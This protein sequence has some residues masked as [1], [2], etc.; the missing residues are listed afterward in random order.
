M[1]KKR[2]VYVVHGYRATS[3][4][5]WFP[6][7]KK[8]LE[9][10]D[11]DVTVFDMPNADAPNAQEWDTYLDDNIVPCNEH[12]IL[13]G[14]SLGCI[15][16]LRYLNRQADTLKIHGLALVSGFSEPLSILPELDLFAKDKIHFDKIIK[17]AE[18][19]LAFAATNDTIVA[20]EY[21]DKLAKQLDAKLVFVENGGHFIDEE[22]CTEFPALL[23]EL[24]KI[25]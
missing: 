23:D 19:R 2:N 25:M 3:D 20:R 9:Q 5:H 12:T 8:E 1:R 18:H 22:G 11:M 14:H 4:R 10:Y 7:L 13:I 21:T 17:M 16:L 24:S 6:W 15:A